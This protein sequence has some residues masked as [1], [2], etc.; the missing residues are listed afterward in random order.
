ML[1]VFLISTQLQHS[2]FASSAKV[3]DLSQSV[4]GRSSSAPAIV[5]IAAAS[6]TPAYTLLETVR[7]RLAHAA[8]KARG[9]AVEAKEWRALTSDELAVVASSTTVTCAAGTYAVSEVLSTNGDAHTAVKLTPT[10]ASCH[11]TNCAYC[12][13]GG[14]SSCIR[15][16]GSKMLQLQI[17][18]G[19]RCVD[20]CA[21]GFSPSTDGKTCR[22]FGADARRRR[23]LAADSTTTSAA[24]SIFATSAA[25]DST[26]TSAAASIF[27]TSAA[28]KHRGRKKYRGK[29]CSKWGGRDNAKC[30]QKKKETGAFECPAWAST[31]C[32][33]IDQGGVHDDP[34]FFKRFGK[35]CHYN[36]E[37][38]SSIDSTFAC[39]AL[40]DETEGC[41]E[42]SFHKSAK[43]CRYAKD[44]QGCCADFPGA[45]ELPILITKRYS[46]GARCVLTTVL[47]SFFIPPP[48]CVCRS[49][50]LRSLWSKE[51]V[52]QPGE[53]CGR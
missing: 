33:K 13:N 12:M 53:Q 27:A 3:V 10:C 36:Y 17:G 9:E 31:M 14:S 23:R 25:A 20:S 32:A 52:H 19:M 49:P 1:L 8:A 22:P 37:E 38:A 7:E 4:S 21:T 6:A 39:A 16:A 43:K 45:G 48:P 5:D 42:F 30:A 29:T 40:C 11:D 51:S 44:D 46:R 15:C 24:A 26:T 2:S 18:G 28:K 50:V 35:I 47:F 41:G 34:S